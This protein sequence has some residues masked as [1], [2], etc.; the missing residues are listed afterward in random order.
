MSAPCRATRPD[1]SVVVM[2]V[3][4]AL[5]GALPHVVIDDPTT[6]EVEAARQH[7]MERGIKRMRREFA[8]WCRRNMP[9]S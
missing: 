3:G 6:A 2:Y 1:G 8:D 4:W 5:A 7:A 9:E